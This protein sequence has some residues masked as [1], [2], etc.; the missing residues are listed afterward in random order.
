MSQ[1]WLPEGSRPVPWPMVVS[2]GVNASAL[3]V[4]TCTNTERASVAQQAAVSERQKVRET[5]L[6]FFMELHAT[7]VV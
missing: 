6:L 5:D 2:L 7:V 1:S 3:S 4:C